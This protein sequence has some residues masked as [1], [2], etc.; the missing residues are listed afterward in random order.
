M[1]PITLRE[2]TAAH[3]AL[4][5]RKTEDP[6]IAAGLPRGF[7]T[8]EEA[9]AAFEKTRLPGADSFGRTVYVGER[10]VGDVWCYGMDPAGQPQAMVSY[11]IF[12]PELWGR[13]LATRAVGD[14][15]HEVKERFS[16]HR[17]GAF[18]YLGNVP[19]VRVLEKNGFRLAEAF[20]EDGVE[21][22]YFEKD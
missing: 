19:S 16:I 8:L 17:F 5:F 12:E 21:S 3:V 18:A 13:G 15:L 10:Y 11:C 22:G 20:S 1:E 7:S 4:Y 9:L 14:F 2:R 6:R